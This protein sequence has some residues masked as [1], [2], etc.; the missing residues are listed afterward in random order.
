MLQAVAQTVPQIEDLRSDWQSNPLGNTGLKCHDAEIPKPLE[1]RLDYI[2]GTFIV[3][4]LQR[5][6]DLLTAIGKRTDDEW[7]QTGTPITRGKQYDS[8]Y[9]SVRGGLLGYRLTDSGTYDCWLSLPGAVVGGLDLAEARDVLRLLDC[10]RFNCTRLDDALDD[11]SKSIDIDQLR[12]ALYSG[13]YYGFRKKAEINNFDDGG[14]TFYFGKR[15]SDKML[16]F[17]NKE[18]ESEGA[19]DCHRW[20]L[21]L[22]DDRAKVAFKMLQEDCSLEDMAARM[23]QMVVGAVD[24]CYKTTIRRSRSAKLEWW[25]TF[26]DLVGVGDGIRLPA[27]R[28]S[29]TLTKSYKWIWK[30]VAPTLAFLWFYF[31][32]AP[33]GGQKFIDNILKQGIERLDPVRVKQLSL[34]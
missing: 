24:F 2:T 27:A 28:R 21:E 32:R 1:V 26:L 3:S 20:E 14:F 33:G 7:A 22:R 31:E 5:A 29:L 25:Q 34:I 10:Y 13:N 8:S 9:G 15:T 12:Q 19:V 6:T 16:R 4:S 17:Y 18:A 11:Y 30:Q 23:A